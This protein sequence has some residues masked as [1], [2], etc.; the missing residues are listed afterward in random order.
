[1]VVGQDEDVGHHQADHHQ[2]L[3]GDQASQVVNLSESVAA[4]VVTVAEIMKDHDHYHEDSI[5]NREDVE[6]SSADV[7][8]P[9]IEL[10]ISL[11]PEKNLN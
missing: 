11:R 7:L 3:Q 2:G 1:M 5:A 8:G 4:R 9:D 10:K 6:R